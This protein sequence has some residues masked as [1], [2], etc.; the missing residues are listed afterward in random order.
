MICLFLGRGGFGAFEDSRGTDDAYCVHSKRASFPCYACMLFV[1][2]VECA[3]R[4]M[5]GD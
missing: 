4:L 5:L 2:V 3:V 1:C